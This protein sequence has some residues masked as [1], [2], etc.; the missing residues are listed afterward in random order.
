MERCLQFVEMGRKP[1]RICRKQ[2]RLPPPKE[3]TLAEMPVSR[4][5][6]LKA[7]VEEQRSFLRANKKSCPKDEVED[8]TAI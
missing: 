3:E 2:A 7:H 4:L 6:V 8:H 5:L 1:A